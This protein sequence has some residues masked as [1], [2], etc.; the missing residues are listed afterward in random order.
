MYK[1]VE[2]CLLPLVAGYKQVFLIKM[3]LTILFPKLVLA[4]ALAG[5]GVSWSFLC[6]FYFFC[7]PFIKQILSYNPRG[8]GEL[9]AISTG[10]SISFH[11]LNNRLTP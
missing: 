6:G 7:F 4:Q 9:S 8:S 5:F 1:L 10:W 11:Q 2:H 3:L